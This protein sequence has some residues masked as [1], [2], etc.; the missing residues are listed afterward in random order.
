MADNVTEQNEAKTEQ[1]SAVMAGENGSELLTKETASKVEEVAAAEEIA[2]TEEIEVTGFKKR[3]ADERKKNSSQQ[4]GHACVGLVLPSP[5]FTP[6]Y[7]L[8]NNKPIVLSLFSTVL[9]SRN[10]RLNAHVFQ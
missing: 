4:I 7:L 6:R 8:L 5:R 3:K 9:H 1:P 10:L 2:V